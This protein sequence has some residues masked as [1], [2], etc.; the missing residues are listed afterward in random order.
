M[1]L[2]FLLVY[3]LLLYFLFILFK[4][5]KLLIKLS[6]VYD[7]NFLFIFE[8]TC[9]YIEKKACGIAQP[10][11]ITYNYLWKWTEGGWE[12]KLGTNVT[13]DNG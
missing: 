10:L 6:Q 1:L 3:L 8:N 7:L 5:V 11:S 13:G 4:L 9:V 2:V 12:L